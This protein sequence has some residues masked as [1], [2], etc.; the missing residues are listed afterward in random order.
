MRIPRGNTDWLALL[1]VNQSVTRRAACPIIT[2]YHAFAYEVQDADGT[3]VAASSVAD[4]SSIQGV[5]R[6]AVLDAFAPFERESGPDGRSVFVRGCFTPPIAPAGAREIILTICS[7]KYR[8]RRV[9][10]ASILGINARLVSVR[11][12]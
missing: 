1:T 2:R 10:N 7:S 12:G 6:S 8:Q 5:A 3:A 9:I 4:P 11:R